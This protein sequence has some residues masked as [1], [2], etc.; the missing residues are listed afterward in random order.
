[1][2]ILQSVWPILDS[3]TLPNAAFSERSWVA[4]SRKSGFILAHMIP[5]ELRHFP[6]SVPMSA[7]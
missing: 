2:R 6:H 4:M 1:M 3:G 5:V 7:V